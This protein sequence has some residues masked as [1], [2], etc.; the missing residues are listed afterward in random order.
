MKRTTDLH[1]LVLL[2]VLLLLFSTCQLFLGQDPDK[3]PMGIFNR[4]WT[5]FNETYAL[6]D[7]RNIDWDEIYGIYSPKIHPTMNDF[8]LFRVCAQMLN[9]LNDSHVNLITPFGHSKY[10][11]TNLEDE[12]ELLLFDM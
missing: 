2:F 6:F 12:L 10:L 1:R 5:D 4:I 11:F 3:S 7:A 9:E 8:E